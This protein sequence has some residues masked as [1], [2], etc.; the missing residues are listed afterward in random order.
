MKMKFLTVVIMESG[1]AGHIRTAKRLKCEI[2][3]RSHI[4]RN[5]KRWCF[6][7]AFGGLTAPGLY[8]INVYRKNTLC[9]FVFHNINK[10]K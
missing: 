3:N 1:S 4:A 2:I 9:T 10:N 6:Y 8:I 5:Q 7:G